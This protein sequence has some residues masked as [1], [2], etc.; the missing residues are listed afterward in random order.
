M[1]ADYLSPVWD[2]SALLII[3][4]QGDFV[5]GPA[6]VA[7]TAERIAPM[8]RLASAFR[9]A[10]RPIVHVIRLYRPGDSDVDAVRRAGVEAGAR[11][12]APNTAGAQIPRE[13]T[14]QELRL[15]TTALLAG[16][17][18]E[19]GPNETV[20][21]KPRWSAFYRTELTDRLQRAAVSTVVVAGCNLP[22]CPRATLFDASERDFRTVL[23]S[24]ATSQCTPQRLA[25]LELIGVNVL[26]TDQVCAGLRPITA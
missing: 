26:D 5:D 4:V 24:D 1:A 7:G 22:N 23:V 3:D 6:A 10:G 19:I 15:D 18:Q 21:Y 25:D 17:F 20:L 11:L 8:V 16:R 14:G 2:R 12:V 9:A 13:L